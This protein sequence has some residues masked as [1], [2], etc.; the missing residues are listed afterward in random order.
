MSKRPIFR[1]VET[2]VTLD[3]EMIPQCQTVIESFPVQ[4]T[5]GFFFQVA[6][7]FCFHFT[8]NVF[9]LLYKGEVS[10]KQQSFPTFARFL[11]SI[12]WFFL[13]ACSLL[14]AKKSTLS[15]E[16]SVF[17]SVTQVFAKK[18]TKLLQQLPLLLSTRCL[19]FFSKKKN[20]TFATITSFVVHPMPYFFFQ[21]KKRTQLKLST[22]FS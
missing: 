12:S 1:E 8:P 13:L 3:T 17:F 21:K 5:K 11:F 22:I 19:T 15:A 9:L 16:L 18:K 2:S 7:S 20:K 14:H 6:I 4:K 10:K